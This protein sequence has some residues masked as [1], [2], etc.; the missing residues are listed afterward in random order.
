SVI[1]C[2]KDISNRRHAVIK[3]SFAVTGARDPGEAMT[4]IGAE[5]I[6]ILEDNRAGCKTIQVWCQLAA[7]AVGAEVI[8]AKAIDCD[9]ENIF[10]FSIR[11]RGLIQLCKTLHWTLKITARTVLINPIA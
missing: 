6:G 8:G 7:V 10:R 1:V 4:G 5:R 11:Q 2:G 9:E 3:D